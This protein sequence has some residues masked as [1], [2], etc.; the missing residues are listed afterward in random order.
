MAKSNRRLRAVFDEAA[1]LYDAV[2]PGYPAAMC[3]DIVA[4][5]GIPPDGRILEIG[6]GTGQAT[7][8]FARRGYRIR[9]VE[10][11]AR[12]AAVARR[13]LSAFPRA[14]VWVGAF[15]EW[16]LEP[17]AF[18]LA[19]SA[20]AFHWLDPAVA[21]PKVARALKPGGA[22]ALFWNE[23]VQSAASRG[24]FEA[25]QEVYRR[26]APEL[27]RQWRPLP[28]P[29][30]VP[31]PVAQEI[32]QTGLFGPV[33]VCRY[34]WEATYDADAYVRLLNTYSGHRNLDQAARKSLSR[35][36]ADLIESRFGGQITKGYL[37]VLYVAHR[38]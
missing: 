34:P 15:E 6:C 23:H 18:D 9:C 35:G 17:A 31:T 2:R 12:M 26:A 27:D 13:N 38:L 4:L 20:T 30:E 33:T 36:I 14:A 10:L 21:Y 25:A 5:S 7:V 32:E 16:P 8:P 19:I 28:W 11:G 3:A 22:I 37:T 29:D 1:L 24:F